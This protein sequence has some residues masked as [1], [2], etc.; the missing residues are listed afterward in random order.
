MN[1]SYLRNL[2]MFNSSNNEIQHYQFNKYLQNVSEY[3]AFGLIFICLFLL[4]QN[5]KM[6][7]KFVFQSDNIPKPLY[8]NVKLQDDI[9]KIVIDYYNEEYKEMPY[10]RKSCSSPTPKPILSCEKDKEF[11]P[12]GNVV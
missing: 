5:K 1:H 12:L 9:N 8:R 3:F 11:F 4:F 7:L 2:T 10:K 6:I